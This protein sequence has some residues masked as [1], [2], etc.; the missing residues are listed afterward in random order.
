[1]LYTIEYFSFN[2]QLKFLLSELNRGNS[3]WKTFCKES[4]KTKLSNKPRS[5]HTKIWE[6]IRHQSKLTIMGRREENFQTF[7]VV[8]KSFQAVNIA[9]KWNYPW[10]HRLLDNVEFF[11][12]CWRHITKM[13]GNLWHSRVCTRRRTRKLSKLWKQFFPTL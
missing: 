3:C 8:E 13:S 6:E 11:V 4:R 12:P 7:W 9:P 1:M 5:A 2:S 10:L